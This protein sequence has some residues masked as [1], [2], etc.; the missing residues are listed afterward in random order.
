MYRGQHKPHFYVL[1]S[2]T[3]TATTEQ[4]TALPLTIQL[5]TV[6]S[7]S[8]SEFLIPIRESYCQ[9]LKRVLLPPSATDTTTPLPQIEKI[10]VTS[11]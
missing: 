9:I 7:K 8:P 3:P 1:D 2:T 10:T 4:N 5:T 6:A 11:N